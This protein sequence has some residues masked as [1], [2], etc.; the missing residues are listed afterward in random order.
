MMGLLKA[1]VMDDITS[2]CILVANNRMQ[3]GD[4]CRGIGGGMSSGCGDG[5]WGG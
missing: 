1:V 2:A 5:L 4:E 3:A